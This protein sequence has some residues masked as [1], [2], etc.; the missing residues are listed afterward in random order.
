[1]GRATAIAVTASAL[2]CTVTACTGDGT[3]DETKAKISSAVTSTPGSGEGLRSSV[4]ETAS[5]AASGIAGAW[6]E[7]KLTAFVAAFRTAYPNLS[8][9]RDDASIESI[10][11]QTCPDIDSGASDEELVAKVP[12]VAANGGTAPTGD[13]AQRIL[14]L[15]RPACP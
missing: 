8:S 12:A 5:S 2:V 1:M 15:V 6:D 10:V 9:D 7:A 3:S 14:Q 11:V 13:Q 4:Q